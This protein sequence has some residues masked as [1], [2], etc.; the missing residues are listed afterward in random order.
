MKHLIA[1]RAEDTKGNV[2]TGTVKAKTYGKAL[3]IAE[4]LLENVHGLKVMTEIKLEC[5]K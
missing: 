4:C 5:L 1:Y 3:K 2:F